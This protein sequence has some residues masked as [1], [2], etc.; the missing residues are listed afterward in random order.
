MT[1]FFLLINYLVWDINNQ[2]KNTSSALG[3]G[4]YILCYFALS[5]ITMIIIAY[6]TSFKNFKKID[7]FLFALCSPIISIIILLI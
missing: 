1:M 5:I 6:L 7:Y 2:T 3:G 4:I